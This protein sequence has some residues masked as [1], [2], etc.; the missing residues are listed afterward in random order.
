MC[1]RWFHWLQWDLCLL[2]CSCGAGF[3]VSS[4]SLLLA[5]TPYFLSFTRPLRFG[6]F[7]VMPHKDSWYRSFPSLVWK[8]CEIL[9]LDL[10]VENENSKT[11]EKG[12]KKI[13][14][15]PWWCYVVLFDHLVGPCGTLGWLLNKEIDESV[16]DN[17]AVRNQKILK[18]SLDVQPSFLF[19]HFKTLLK[20][21]LC[22]PWI[23]R[24][25]VALLWL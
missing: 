3:K 16:T 13:F 12:K 2:K 5:R 9:P 22:S 19:Q 11:Y 8:Y 23:L 20:W 10:D 15:L 18:S 24:D 21:S 17:W 6:S 14:C 1:S 4:E 7:F 25:R